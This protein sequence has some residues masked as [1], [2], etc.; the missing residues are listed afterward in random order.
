MVA[1]VA[2]QCR[3]VEDEGV[4]RVHIGWTLHATGFYGQVHIL[5]VVF[6]RFRGK[7]E[8][9]FQLALVLACFFEIVVPCVK[10]V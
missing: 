1:A 7:D 8:D 3:V 9:V 2:G 10:V 4:S 5:K 6:A